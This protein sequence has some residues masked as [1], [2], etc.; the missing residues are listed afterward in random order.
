MSVK[1]A[2]SDGMWATKAMAQTVVAAIGTTTVPFEG[3]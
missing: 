2:E 1:M 3:G